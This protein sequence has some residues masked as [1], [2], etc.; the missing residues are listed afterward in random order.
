M[1]DVRSHLRRFAFVISSSIPGSNTK[2]LSPEPELRQ[3][4][5]C[6]GSV[7]IAS[8]VS[9]RPRPL[10]PLKDSAMEASGAFCCAIGILNSNCKIPGA[11]MS[12]T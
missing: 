9:G 8:V 4:Q 5:A 7:V 12:A 10:V 3:R 11:I 1:I 6:G 2:L